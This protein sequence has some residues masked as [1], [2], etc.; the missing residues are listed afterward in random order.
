[1]FHD[2][3][4]RAESQEADYTTEL[5]EIETAIGETYEMS[6]ESDI[7]AWITAS[8]LTTAEYNEYNNRRTDLN[9]WLE[10]V[11]GEIQEFEEIAE[12]YTA[13]AAADAEARM[14]AAHLEELAR[15]AVERDAEEKRIKQERKNAAEAVRAIEAE[16]A[17]NAANEQRIYT[18]IANA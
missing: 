5:A 15:A 3:V 2:R 17:L 1:L 14:A 8:G 9:E 11:E 7:E 13:A 4:G 16:A 12:E 6:L 10:A 18:A